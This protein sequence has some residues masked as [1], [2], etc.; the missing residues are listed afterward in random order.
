MTNVLSCKNVYVRAV[1]RRNEENGR[2]EE[3]K[4]VEEKE[5]I[6]KTLKEETYGINVNFV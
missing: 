4:I 5:E 2:G 6:E 1:W 3:R